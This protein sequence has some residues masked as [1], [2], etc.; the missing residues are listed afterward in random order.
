LDEARFRE[1]ECLFAEKDY[2]AAAEAFL[3]AAGGPG[4][5]GNGVAYH[6]AGNALLQLRKYSHAVT[7]YAHALKDPEY[8]RRSQVLANCGVAYAALG[9]YEEA[10]AAFDA[11]LADASYA[12]RYKALQGKAGALYKMGRFEEAAE[13]YRTAAEDPANTECGRAYNNLGLTLTELRRPREAVEAYRRSLSCAAYAGQGKAAVN[14][15]LLYSAAG[16]SAEAVRAF[17]LAVDG[18]GHQ[19]SDVALQAYARGRAAVDAATGSGSGAGSATRETPPAPAAAVAV[20]DSAEDT[21][22]VP[23]RASS[24]LED[25]L[26]EAD[27]PESRF[28]TVTDSEMKELDR[29]AQREERANRRAASNPWARAASVAIGVLLVV[30]ACS[31]VFFAG[32]G[33]PTQEGTVAGMLD[34]YKQGKEVSEY[35]VGAPVSDI[36]KEMSSIHPR[37]RGYTVDTVERGPFTSKARITVRLEQ[38]APMHYTVS[39][40]REGVGWKVLGIEND[41]GAAGGSKP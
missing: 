12:A 24:P 15:G 21:A 20:E 11:T 32:Y 18:H 28:F 34:A 17:D 10:I 4:G 40:Q 31:G 9:D 41:W 16:M 36:G 23:A 14:L 39:L 6:M 19:L 27:E 38:G 3:A 8:A 33:Y 25:A 35:W 26:A 22:E 1:A 13:G 29:E 2:R 37:Y 7:V 5:P 30:G